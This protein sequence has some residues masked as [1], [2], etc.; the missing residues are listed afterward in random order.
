MDICNLNTGQCGPSQLPDEEVIILATPQVQIL[1][2]TDPYCSHCWAY[3]PVWRK[4]LFLYRPFISVRYIYGGLLPSW[5]GM[6]RGGITGPA[7]LVPHYAEVAQHYGQPIDSTVLITDPPGSSYP[8]SIA[9]HIVRALE[10]TREEAYLR[11]IRQAVFLE[12]RNFARPEVLADCAA[13]IGLDRQHFLEMFQQGHGK[14]AFQQD[15]QEARQLNA[16]GFPT[17]FL[18]GHDNQTRVLRGTQPFTKLEQAFLQI[19]GLEGIET[20]P[21]TKE[22]LLAYG[23]GT[24]REFAEVLGLEQEATIDSLITAGARRTPLAGDALWS[25]V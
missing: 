8:P 12:S 2:V 20:H 5:D 25:S 14:I 19:S 6:S 7:D 9:T 16:T 21:S 13:D 1:F 4:F 24:T 22:V 23:S 17:L 10:P 15:L 3:E 18:K 11:R